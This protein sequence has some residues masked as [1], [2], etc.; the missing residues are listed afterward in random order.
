MLS[1]FGVNPGHLAHIATFSTIRILVIILSLL[2]VALLLFA[3]WMW[4]LYS[5]GQDS[6]TSTSRRIAEAHRHIRTLLDTLYSDARFHLI[7]YEREFDVDA[8]TGDARMRKTYVLKSTQAQTVMSCYVEARTHDDAER[9]AKELADSCTGGVILPGYHQFGSTIEG[10]EIIGFEVEFSPPVHDLEH[11][12]S[13]RCMLKSYISG[14]HFEELVHMALP[15]ERSIL[16]F[17]FDPPAQ[18]ANQQTIC[19]DANSLAQEDLGNQQFSVPAEGEIK[20][21]IAQPKFGAFYK[22]M[23]DIIRA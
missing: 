23:F 13:M 15:T 7:R 11:T 19:I 10:V 5:H 2:N 14:K 8:S 4:R 17:S 9:I 1:F 18:F 20:W 16:K 12:L 3:V 21:E 22:V 6:I